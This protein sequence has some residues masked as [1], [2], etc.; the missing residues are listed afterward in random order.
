MTEHLVRWHNAVMQSAQLLSGSL[1]A[2][3]W[4]RQGPVL[5]E[6]SD[7]RDLHESYLFLYRLAACFC[8][9][10]DRSPS[11][12]REIA[13]S[14]RG[15]PEPP[16]HPEWHASLPESLEAESD[17]QEA[18]RASASVSRLCTNI[19]GTIAK[20]ASR[21]VRMKQHFVFTA[22][23]AAH[24]LDRLDAVLRE[25]VRGTW[26]QEEALECAYEWARVLFDFFTHHA[27]YLF[28][29]SDGIGTSYRKPTAAQTV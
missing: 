10:L 22:E 7:L 4:P 27:V 9:L 2:P 12:T 26:D 21:N 16:E 29:S 20:S 14:T 8:H 18:L 1:D 19:V 15:A 23:Y 5:K 11:F 17:F 25:G 13:I 3:G 28:S 24:Q 6:S